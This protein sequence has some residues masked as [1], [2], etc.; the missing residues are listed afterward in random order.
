MVYRAKTDWQ[1]DET[2]TENDLNRIEQGIKDAYETSVSKLPLV[3]IS[4][5]SGRQVI[6]SDVVAPLTGL[7]IKGRTLVNLLG[8]SGGFE[9]LNIYGEGWNSWQVTAT[10]QGGYPTTTGRGRCAVKINAGQ[11][12]GNIN[13]YV[14]TFVS[15]RFYIALADIKNHNLSG[16]MRIAI[17]N[18]AS[19]FSP[20]VT[21]TAKYHTVFAKAAPTSTTSNG[22]IEL[23]VVGDAGQEAFVD[24]VRV[25]EITRAEY[26]ALDS[27][28]P[29]QIAEKWPYV[30][31]I[32]SVYSPYIIKNDENLL[33]PFT[34]WNVHQTAGK[35]LEPYLLHV[36]TT[37]TNQYTEIKGIKVVPGKQYTLS[38][39]D[40]V[41]GQ[42]VVLEFYDK[43]GVYLNGSAIES[44]AKSITLLAPNSAETATVYTTNTTA[45][46]SYTLEK[47]MLNIGSVEIP[48]KPKN[49]DQ[50]FFPNVQLA[51]NVD[52]TVYDTL[53]Q[54]GGKYWKRTRFRTMNLTGDLNWIF[55]NDF[56]GFKEAAILNFEKNCVAN[57]ETVV[58]YSG[59]VLPTSRDTISD[60]S[61]L[62]SVG[63]LLIRIPDTDSGW[64]EEYKPSD[65]EVK[66]YFYGWKMWHKESSDSAVPYNGDGTRAW[67]SYATG[68][69]TTVLPRSSDGAAY[70]PYHLQ[71]QLETPTVEEIAS[72]GGI[73]LHKGA[74]QIEV[75]TGMIVR[76]RANVGLDSSY[77]YIND[78]NANG[79]A[80]HSSQTK[81]RLDKFY[82]IYKN[83]QSDSSWNVD[84]VSPAYG[85]VRAWKRRSDYDQSAAYTVTYLALDQY[86]LSCN[87]LS[88]EAAYPANMKSV[89]DTL[90]AGHADMAARVGALEITRAQ[91]AQPQWITPTLMNGWVSYGPNEAPA[92]YN[93]DEFNIVRLRGL[94][95]PGAAIPGTVILQLPAR[96]RPNYIRR[97]TVP[98]SGGGVHSYADLFVNTL[99]ELR[100]DVVPNGVVWVS[101]DPI[102]FTL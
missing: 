49:D 61:N 88:L 62:Q 83:E 55:N 74:N 1:F 20:Y 12:A 22:G 76:E 18:S 77:A 4:L 5:Q 78:L 15:G 54:S 32:K 56:S 79:Q 11:T 67:K 47:P 101:L 85:K 21:D 17:A 27:M 98:A 39:K 10:T 48:F 41:L 6:E 31:D 84:D 89:V 73:T 63:H 50:L 69:E 57:S 29:E 42:K 44:P 80:N 70:R 25:Y 99:G 82:G 58:K 14:L 97:F 72:E 2:V 65:E 86:A 35:V 94:I 37:S 52:G 33:P 13:R 81:Y 92:E 45:T 19:V 46:I 96:Y 38:L 71:Y 43:S 95:K 91:R 90:A 7:Q 75:G 28:T 8:R 66:A 68:A 102:A 87:L 100:I 53:F 9:T 23:Q 60:S 93:L 51:S 36:E 34:D 26:D 16:G 59:K 64:G 30:D 40:I 24:S 3:P